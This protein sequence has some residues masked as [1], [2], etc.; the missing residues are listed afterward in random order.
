MS[1]EQLALAAGMLIVNLLAA[2]IGGTWVLGRTSADLSEKI[3]ASRLESERNFGETVQAIRQ[4]ISDMELW[5]RDHFVNKQTFDGVMADTRE[6]LRRMEDK[7]DR[8]FDRF[9]RKLTNMG[10]GVG[11]T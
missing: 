5:N 4:K 3:D 11:E 6:T 8:A 7:I 1:L 9:D 10:G 2:V